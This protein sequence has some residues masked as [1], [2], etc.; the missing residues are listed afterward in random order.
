MAIT[1]QY[2][3]VDGIKVCCETN[4]GPAQNGTIVCL[5]S[6]GRDS[7]QFHGIM[8]ALRDEFAVAAFDMPGHG[9]T[10]PLQGN[11][12]IS[13]FHEYGDFVIKVVSELGIVNPIYIGCALGG[14]TV[15]YIAQRQQVR[16]I[17][18]MAGGDYT[19]N[20]DKSVTDLLNHPY[21]N[22]QF[23]HFDFTESLIGS[24]AS[25]ADKDFILW[26]VCSE[27]GAVKAA[28]YGGVFNG[29]DVRD[30]MGDITC[31]VLILRG[32]EDW[33]A[34]EGKLKDIMGRMRNAKRIDYRT[35]PRLG[36][37]SPQESPQLVAN[38]FSGF[39]NNLS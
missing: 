14:N 2:L 27:S 1:A 3:I 29:F 26:G 38:V 37:Y 4:N 10:W 8:D 16:A 30:G 36:H 23:S 15:F 7:R 35:L 13:E 32:E 20:V 25:P 22:V 33:S 39:I 6:A 19:P 18:S 11:R 34:S 31:P 24:A 21:C 17:V 12:V 28:D 9:K 5:G